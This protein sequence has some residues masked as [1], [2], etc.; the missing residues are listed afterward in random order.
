MA[1]HH[2]WNAFTYERG[3]DVDVELV[4]LAGVEGRGDQLAAADHPDVFSRRGA[5]TLRKCL[6]WFRHEFHTWRRPPRRFLEN[7]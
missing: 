6:H 7:T 5:Q 4:D 3:N 2:K 1:R